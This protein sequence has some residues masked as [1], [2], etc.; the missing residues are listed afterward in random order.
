[1]TA[2]QTFIPLNFL[3]VAVGAATGAWLRW[4]LSW[5][6]NAASWPWGTFMV[7]LAGGYLVG[8]VLALVLVH[9]EWPSWVRLL[10]V[11]GFLGGL[12]TFSTFSAEM[13]AMLE[14]GAYGSALSYVGASLLG[15][16]LLTMLGL[17]SGYAWRAG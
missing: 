11:T 15:S 6:L 17:V 14:Q 9:P 8:L 13:V 5:W 2:S 7:N 4:S 3:V 16:V 12:T 10:L 1:M